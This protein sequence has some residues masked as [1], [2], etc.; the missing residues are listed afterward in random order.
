MCVCVY[1]HA[2]ACV[3]ITRL[4]LEAGVCTLK[5]LRIISDLLIFVNDY[6]NMRLFFTCYVV[7][8][9][10]HLFLKFYFYFI[11]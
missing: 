5:Y 9:F 11:F 6:K 10:I 7:C 4:F 1:M 2:C 8:I 3:Y